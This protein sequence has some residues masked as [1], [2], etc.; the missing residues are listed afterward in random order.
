MKYQLLGLLTAAFLAACSN[1]GNP[2]Q[3]SVEEQNA[4]KTEIAKKIDGLRTAWAELDAPAVASFFSERSLDTYNGSRGSYAD[5]M[6][7]AAVGYTGIDSTDI[8]EFQDYRVDILSPNAVV[9]SWQNRVDE[10][11][12]G[13]DTVT[14]YIAFM[15]QV[16]IRE[17]GEWRLLHN[18]EST[19]GLDTSD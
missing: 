9:A 18:H 17:G 8:G 2:E 5:Q 4:I 6:E 10:T 7:W 1:V 14:R 13:Q 12:T 15:T 16:W 19:L 3:M 11:A